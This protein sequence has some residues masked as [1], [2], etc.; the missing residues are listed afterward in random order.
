MELKVA[1]TEGGQPAERQR[2]IARP[3]PRLK[4]EKGFLGLGEFA[5][6][7]ERRAAGRV[8]RDKVPRESHAEWKESARRPDPIDILI[9]S[10]RGRMPQLVPIRHSR[11]LTSPFAFLR[12]SAAVMAAD[13]SRTPVSGLRVQACGDCHL[14]NFGAFAT[15]ERQMVMDINDFDETLPAPWEWDLKRLAASIVVAG[16]YIDFKERDALAAATSAVRSYRRWM[17]RYADMRTLEVWYDHIDMEQVISANSKVAP[18]AVKRF[19]ARIAKAHGRSVVEQD[20]P[21][22]TERNGGRP[23]IKDNAPL[24]FHPPESELKEVHASIAAAFKLYR[25]SLA[26]HS[27]VLFDRFKFYDLAV[28]VVG[29]GSVGTF[30][31]VGL[32]MAS[33]S[34]P[35]FLQVKQANSSVLEPYTGK[36]AYSNHGQR[37]VVGQR[38]MQAASDMMLG[39]TFGKFLGRHFYIRQLRDMKLCAI[40][41]GWEPAVLKAYGKL[42]GR[43]LAR[44]HARSGD[45]AMISGYLGNSDVFDQAVTKFAGGLCRPDRARPQGTAQGG[46]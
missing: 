6:P 3:R 23:R 30:C 35:L 45:P 20:F 2:E 34:D 16:R 42:C 31:L 25:E 36:S 41:E 40:I 39:W 14:M 19:R 12:G 18:E 17:A 10:N 1:K 21:K 9:A 32:F 24:I 37:V 13:L 46:G 5:S 26:D 28:K 44:A 38:L 7:E 33:D 11:M 8:L 27:R 43:I 4:L 22:L 15:P 29:V